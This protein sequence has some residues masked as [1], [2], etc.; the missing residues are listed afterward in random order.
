M[1]DEDSL[2]DSLVILVIDPDGA[3]SRIAEIARAKGHSV[4]TAMGIETAIVVIGGLTPDLV[5]VRSASP[6]E[7]VQTLAAL[8]AACPSVPTRI[9]KETGE[10][11]EDTASPN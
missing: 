7:N 4:M 10:S 5:L 11:V 9:V 6:I 3:G 2:E 8:A 1:H